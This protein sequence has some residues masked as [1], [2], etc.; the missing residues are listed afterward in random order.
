MGNQQGSIKKNIRKHP[1]IPCYVAEDGEIYNMEFRKR[2][3]YLHRSGYLRVDL[4]YK[5]KRYHI[6]VHR[7]VAETFLEP[8][9][10]ELLEICSKEHHKKV[11]V[12]HKDND[13]MNN[14]FTNLKWGTHQENIS[15]AFRDGMRRSYSGSGNPAA[16]LTESVVEDICKS[17][18]S[19]KSRKEVREI[20][21]ITYN[22]A[23]FIH[24]KSS[25]KHITSKY[26]F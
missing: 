15:Q 23:Y 7:A 8:P 4:Q 13:R 22:Q 25:W 12:L 10:E 3:P 5:K 14:H 20:F 26:S 1:T 18:E 11:L 6:Q 21:G 2:S 19:G 9:S 24:T 16:K 17:F